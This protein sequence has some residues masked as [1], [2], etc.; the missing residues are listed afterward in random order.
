VSDD[1]DTFKAGDLR[2]YHGREHCVVVLKQRVYYSRGF[3]GLR[4]EVEDLVEGDKFD[5][6]QAVLG[7]KVNEMEALAWVAR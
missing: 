5:C 2:I 1:L 7:R 6:Y 4:W 3:N